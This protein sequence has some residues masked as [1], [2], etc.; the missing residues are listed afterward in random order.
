MRNFGLAMNQ[1]TRTRFAPTPSGYLHLGNVFSFAVTATFA[2]RSGAR[3]LLRIDDLDYMRVKRNYVE[4]IFDTLAFLKLPWDEGPRSYLE[5]QQRYSQIQRMDLYGDALQQ[6]R[7][8]GRLFAC[9]CS[10][11][12]LF[13]RHPEGIYTGTCLNK[14]I[15]LDDP[16]YNWRL[17]TS[18]SKLPPEMQYF[19]VRKRDGFP[20]YQ[21]ASVVDDVHYGV[22]LVVRGNDLRASTQAQLYLAGLLGYDS[23]VSSTFYHHI[24]LVDPAL[25]KLSKSTGATSI[26]YLRKLGQTSEDIF[27][28]VGQLVGL[29]EPVSSWEQLA[30]DIAD[31]FMKN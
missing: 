8:Q 18:G 3:I 12:T 13:A 2:K 10:R 7:R 21:L 11:S 4:D 16:G 14:D 23:F 1:F 20:A 17:N 5:Y 31:D 6:L 26:Q 25:E 19:V 22:D 30:V 29:A 15:S 27:Q 9:D 28:K 24:L